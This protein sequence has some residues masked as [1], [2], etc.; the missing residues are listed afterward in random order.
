MKLS[1]FFFIFD[2]G[3]REG[4]ANANE[5]YVLLGEVLPNFLFLEQI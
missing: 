4:G 1:Y 5:K 3:I 2:L